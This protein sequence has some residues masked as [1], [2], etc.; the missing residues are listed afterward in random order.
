MKG[1]NFS[2][3]TMSPLKNPNPVPTKM[4]RRRDGS[5][6]TP[7]LSATPPIS[8]E[9]II[10]VPTERSMPPEMMTNVTPIEMNPI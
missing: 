5:I 7:C 6:G 8:A 3:D 1:G 2:L 4:M 10:T 9:A